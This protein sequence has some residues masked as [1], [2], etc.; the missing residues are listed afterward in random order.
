MKRLIIV[1]HGNTFLPDAK[2]TRI[3]RHTNLPLVDDMLPRYIGQYLNR[4]GININKA[5]AAPLIRTM[6]TAKLIL[7]EMDLSLEIQ[8]VTDFLEID[9]GP[10]EN[11][12]EEEVITRL[13]KHE[14]IKQGQLPPSIRAIK[15]QGKTVI[16]NWN[17]YAKVPDGW[18]ADSHRIIETWRQF[19]NQIYD[20]ETVLVVSSNGIIRFVPHILPHQDY[21]DFL[22]HESLKVK[23]GSIAIFDYENGYWQC[24]LWNERPS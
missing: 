16:D 11:K 12:T 24:N 10:D 21:I 2:P 6:Q 9:Y 8:P 18:L 20:G 3:G 15:A 13:G 22:R 4:R 23:T 1:R 17:S 19:A 5:Y 14:F 7:E